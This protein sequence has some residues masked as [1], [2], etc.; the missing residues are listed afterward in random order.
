MEP[1]GLL[2]ASH[3]RFVVES[4]F[5]AES[6]SRLVEPE[7]D[8]VDR[9]TE[10]LGGLGVGEALPQHQGEHVAVGGPQ[11]SDGGPH[12][13]GV[14]RGTARS[15]PAPRVSR[16]LRS[17]SPEQ[18]RTPPHAPL[19]AAQYTAGH[20]VEPQSISRRVRYLVQA[21]PGGGKDLGGQVRCVLTRSEE[22]SECKGVD[23]RVVRLVEDLEPGLI[24]CARWVPSRLRIPLILRSRPHTHMS[25]A[26]SGIFPGAAKSLRVTSRVQ[27]STATGVA[28]GQRWP[29][30]TGD[31]RAGWDRRRR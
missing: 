25:P 4:E 24:G 29:V 19:V 6:G 12:A 26:R 2:R 27:L 28:R 13:L 10:D 5:P 17:Q 14:G 16:R 21:T 30:T 22:P 1:A 3:R 23:I 18:L 8:S 11:A 20:T 9:T 31:H 15:G 7:G